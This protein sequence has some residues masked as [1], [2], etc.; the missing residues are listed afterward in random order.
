MTK[1]FLLVHLGGACTL[2]ALVAC[3]STPS[4]NSNPGSCTDTGETSANQ[5]ADAGGLRPFSS[6]ADP[7]PNGIWFSASGEVLALGGYAFP[8]T[9]TDSV[10]FVDGWEMHF[11]EL[12]VTV[13]NIRLAQN[14]D[15][16]AGDE[17][18]TGPE[19]AKVTGPWAIDLHKGGPLQGKGGSDE[20]AVPI[21][22]LTGQN[23]NDCAPFDLT[24]KYAFSF[25]VVEATDSALN[26]N[27]DAQGLADYAEMISDGYTVLYIGTATFLGNSAGNTCTPSDLEFTKAPLTENSVVNFRLGFKSPTSY[28]NCQNPSLSGTP[29]GID[30]HP[31]GIYAYNNQSSIAQV[32]IHTDHPFWDSTVHDSP[33]H[34]DQIAARYTETT[35]TPTALVEDMTSVDYT[36]FTDAQGNALPWRDCVGTNFVPPDSGTMHFNDAAGATLR[37]YAEF[38]T[39][40]QRTQ[41]HLNSDGLCYVKFD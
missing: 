13:D 41:G 19:V 24:Q 31:R 30:E 3:T 9:G 15:L 27:L 39:Y 38:M 17:S 4:K 5:G 37:N 6:P 14:P 16:N 2:C 23:E 26:V 10:A 36:H 28:I 33:M 1:S 12:L 8:P 25:D 21:A 22:A 40:D 32:T 7:G 20:Q 11:S 18:Q 34:F 29:L 35:G